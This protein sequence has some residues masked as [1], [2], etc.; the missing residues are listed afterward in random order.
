MMMMKR[1]IHPRF[2]EGNTIYFMM[3]REIL[4]QT[5]PRIYLKHLYTPIEVNI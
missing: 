2:E 3:K 1:E 4:W 5:L